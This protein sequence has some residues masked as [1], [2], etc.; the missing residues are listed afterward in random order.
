MLMFFLVEIIIYAYEFDKD[1]FLKDDFDKDYIRLFY[2]VFLS[3]KINKI[4]LKGIWF[5]KNIS[6]RW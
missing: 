4:K 1:F 3:E 2:E 6:T 5:I